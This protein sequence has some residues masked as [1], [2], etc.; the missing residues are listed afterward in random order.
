MSKAL[1]WFR[2]DLRLIDNPGLA[3]A[4]QSHD[5]ILLI[6]ILD[7]KVKNTAQ[8]WWL[9]FS[10]CNLIADLNTHHQQ[11]ILLEGEPEHLIQTLIEHHQID[12]V[13][14][15]RLYE[16]Q[17]IERDQGIKTSLKSQGIKVQSYNAS[18]LHEP[19][20][21]KNKQGDYFK[22]FTPYWKHCLNQL[23]PSTP[24]M[25]SNWP[26]LIYST[27]NTLEDWA[28]L[29]SKPNW[30][31]DFGNYWTPGETGAH[32]KLKDFIE[33][34]IANYKE[35]R[36]FPSIEACSGLSPHLHFGEIGPWQIYRCTLAYQMQHPETLEHSQH[37]L[38][39][40]GWREFSYYLLYHFP[41]LPFQNFKSV[42][43]AFPW[44]E[45]TPALKKWQLGQTGYPIVD[46]G[47]RE[48]WLSGSMHNRVRMIVA[49][50]LIKNLFIDWREGAQWFDH[51][52]LDA[53][54]ASNYA[55]WQWVAGSGADAAPYFRI[56]NP[57]LQGEKFDPDGSYVKK[58]V[59][60]LKEVSTK[61]IH[62]PWEAP[63]GALSI[64]LGVDY[65]FPMVKHQETRNQALE[66][67]KTIKH[68]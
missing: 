56:F 4:C 3:S 38:S 1:F 35:K 51:T 64:R 53:D 23:Q 39:E 10:L 46:A 8:A 27:S 60:E 2:Q 48:L 65:P 14:W 13:Y 68:L 7:P 47:M 19:W 44:H 32:A 63:L 21:I 49:S 52:L 54:M 11:L 45:N 29:P 25:I 66:Y 15:N 26:K 16:P 9:H 30:A 22:V 34:K 5:E 58:W 24:S 42:F 31:I 18:L 62:Q 28:L 61:W 57:I 36:N 41:S 59:P 12:A 17:W 37:F 40:L 20:T 67:Y 55:S 6:Y 33:H 43:D 50:F